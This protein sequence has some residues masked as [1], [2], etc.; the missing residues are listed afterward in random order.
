MNLPQG[1]I[2]G[3]GHEKISRNKFKIV[4]RWGSR[5]KPLAKWFNYG[6]KDHGPRFYQRLH[7]K[8]KTTGKDIYARWVHGIPKTNAMEIGMELGKDRFI[9]NLLLGGKEYVTKELDLV[10]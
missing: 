4:N 10:Q 7:W 2:D 1:F 9:H 3:V 8:D 5:E 6:T